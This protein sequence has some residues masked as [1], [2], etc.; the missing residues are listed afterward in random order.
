VQ[1]VKTQ[2]IAPEAVNEPGLKITKK[3]GIN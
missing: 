3:V 2:G 1:Y